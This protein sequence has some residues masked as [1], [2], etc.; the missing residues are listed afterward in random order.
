VGPNT[1]RLLADERQERQESDKSYLLE[2]ETIAGN[3]KNLAATRSGLCECCLHVELTDSLNPRHQ[4]VPGGHS[5]AFLEDRTMPID[6]L[7]LV[8]GDEVAVMPGEDSRPDEVIEIQSVDA[9]GLL[10]VRVRNDRWFAIFGGV[11]MNSTGYIVPATDEHRA[12]IK[13][14]GIAP[15]PLPV[16]LRAKNVQCVAFAE[17]R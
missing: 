13:C 15:A 1:N 2:T 10:R 14:Q 5:A 17:A 11:G 6:W 3:H 9:V 4:S 8:F 12:I 16:L 7:D